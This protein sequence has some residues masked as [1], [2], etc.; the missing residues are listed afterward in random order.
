MTGGAIVE[1]GREADVLEAVAFGRWP[2]QAGELR[3]VL[4]AAQA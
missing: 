4:A 2:D 1:C 3:A